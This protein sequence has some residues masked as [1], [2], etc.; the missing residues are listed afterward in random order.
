MK[1]KTM[2]VLGKKTGKE[3][4]DSTKVVVQESVSANTQEAKNWVN[5]NNKQTKERKKGLLQYR[6]EKVGFVLTKE[7][8]Q[9]LINKARNCGLSLSAY[10]VAKV[11][12][13]RNLP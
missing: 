1:G 9:I 13:D 12:Y 2:A 4:E 8:K 5:V 7:E 6:Q 11:I 10:I 3:F